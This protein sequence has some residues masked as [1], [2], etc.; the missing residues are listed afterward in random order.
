MMHRSYPASRCAQAFIWLLLAVATIGWAPLAAAAANCTT[1]SQTLTLP[2]VIV[3]ST[4]VTAGTVLATS[5][6]VTMIF[7]CSGLPVST[8]RPADFNATIQAGQTLATLD[9]TNNTGGPGITFKLTGVSGLALLVTATPVQATSAGGQVSD[10]PNS[11]AGYPVG[12]VT[13]PAG[14]AAGSFTGTVAETF[15]AQL[16]V[17]GPIT[18]GSIQAINTLIPFWWYIP[19][20]S[21][22]SSSISMNAPLSLAT[23]KV[24]AGACSVNIASQNLTVVLPS[25]AT[26]ALNGIGTT[27]G[28]TPFNVDLTCQSSTKT[29]LITMTASNPSTTQTGVILP[30]TGTGFASNVGVQ[31][32]NGSGNP[33]NVRGT[34]QS[35]GKAPAG[36]LSIPYFAQ[37][38]QT[39]T[40]V[41]VGQVNATVTFNITFQ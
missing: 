13:A 21:Q 19:G 9:S 38:Y 22:D 29:V 1:T 34:A 26:S 36:S 20:G 17:T 15:T 40:P 6:P 35:E 11:N 32:L 16:I 28:Q 7:S 18:V 10:G 8:S 14:A 27:A 2:D 25:I 41:T 39:G 24:S 3:P 4:A 5:S 12:S 37:Y 33:V 30:T 31:L 23:S